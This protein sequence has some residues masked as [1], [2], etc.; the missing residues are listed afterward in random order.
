M[1][2]CY[3]GLDQQYDIQLKVV[4]RPPD[5]IQDDLAQYSGPNMS[6]LNFKKNDLP[7][8]QHIMDEAIRNTFGEY[9]HRMKQDF[10]SSKR[11]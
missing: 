2:D 6:A 11:D 1:S 7:V 4:P 8:A 9:C 10:L 5:D 3:L